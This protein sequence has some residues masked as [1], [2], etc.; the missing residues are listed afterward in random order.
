MFSS[1]YIVGLDVDVSYIS[2]GD[3]VI[4]E[5][6]KTL[7]ACSNVLLN[8]L[9]H[10]SRNQLNFHDRASL[11]SFFPQLIM[12]NRTNDWFC[13]VFQ[14]DIFLNQSLPYIQNLR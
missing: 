3:Y 2:L 12:F 4:T 14:R 11:A 1:L 5:K 6:Y 8:A 7:C 10:R 9:K 13:Y